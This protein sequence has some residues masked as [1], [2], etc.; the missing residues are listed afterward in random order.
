MTRTGEVKFY[1][2]MAI[3][4]I[5]LF[6]LFFLLPLFATLSKAFILDNKFS[7]ENLKA[8]ITSKYTLQILSFTILQALISALISILIAFPGAYYFSNYKARGKRLILSLSSLCFTLPSI[9]VVL[10][11]VIFY[12]N[13]GLI[14]SI[15]KALFNLE[16]PP[17][18]ILYT[19]KAIIMAH[20][21]LNIPI[22]LS[23]ITDYYSSLPRSVEKVAA[24]L[25]ASPIK[26]FFTIN[27]PRLIPILLSAF[28]LIFL[29]CFS[30]FAIILVLG[31]GPQFTTIE[32]EIYRQAKISL[33]YNNAASFA[34]L[35]LFFNL[36]ILTLSSLVSTRINTKEERKQEVL[37]K[38]KKKV[39]KVLFTIYFTLFIL[40]IL[41]PLLAIVYRSFISTSAKVGIGFSLNQYQMLLGNIR[42]TGG[43]GPA[44]DAIRN[45]LIIAVL[46]A[47]ISST[48]ALFIV[49]YIANKKKGRLDIIL[50]LPMAVSSV[51]IGLGFLIIKSVIPYHSTLLGY[52]LVIIAHVIIT[53]PFAIKTILPSRLSLNTNFLNSAYTIGASPLRACLTL[54]IPQLLPSLSKAF[55]FTFALSMGE[56]NATLLLTE[57]KIITLPVLLYRLIG[58][59]NFQGACAL[60]TLLIAITFI[61]FFITLLYDK[62]NKK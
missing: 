37:P 2:R 47:F 27:F 56:V 58:S 14:N 34:L 43:L 25:G 26:I 16:N 8:V 20:A 54:E 7:L 11:F 15:L 62:R 19:F 3:F 17:L 22:A 28:L 30:S 59:Y 45:S 4:P 52:T 23:L 53:L 46:T 61:I 50:M 12:G 38:N 36:I 18:K 10:G 44:I 5:I 31:G 1:H 24:T 39:S 32:V 40:S 33:N 6:S 60:G 21:F 55:I 29:F 41:G 9:L 51:I 57:G 48:F 42:A 13:S 35:S 49:L